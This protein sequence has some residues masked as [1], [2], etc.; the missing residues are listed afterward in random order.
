MGARVFEIVSRRIFLVR[1]LLLTALGF[2]GEAR[3]QLARVLRYRPLSRPVLIPLDEVAATWRA[4]SFVADAVTLSSA[5][6][7]NQPIR[8]SGIVVRVSAAEP[9]GSGRPDQFAAVCVR[10]PHELCDVDYVSD[11]RKLANEIVEEIGKPVNEPV[12]VCPCHNSTFKADGE[13]LAG[14][15]P[16]G[17]YTFRVTRLTDAAVE[18]GEVE[19]DV[20]IFV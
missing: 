5:A 20:L 4:R 12:Y 17:L 2:A 3:A 14:P 7:P 10:C 11:P 15:A 18:I 19:E 9:G 8:V 1:G 13:R 6:T 16:R